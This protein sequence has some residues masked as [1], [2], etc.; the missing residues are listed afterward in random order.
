MLRWNRSCEGLTSEVA[1][2]D[3]TEVTRGQSAGIGQELRGTDVTE[4]ARGTEFWGRAE[5]VRD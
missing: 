3:V 1:G 4:V 2:A 5:V